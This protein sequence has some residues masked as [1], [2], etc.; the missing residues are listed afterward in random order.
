[1]SLESNLQIEANTYQ[2]KID[3]LEIAKNELVL[4]LERLSIPFKEEGSNWRGLTRDNGD[5]IKSNIDYE[6]KE[7]CR[8]T[9][10][11]IVIINS[12]ISALKSRKS[13]LLYQL[14]KIE[15]ELK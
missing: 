15:N 3:R 1:M 9:D 2:K 6:L 10:E 8:Q 13:N 11:A 4:A 12:E 5:K 7:I 14:S